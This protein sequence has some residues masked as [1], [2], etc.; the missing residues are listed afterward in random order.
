[1]CRLHADILST[2]SIVTIEHGLTNGTL[3]T[4]D[5]R[6]G[7]DRE[8][9]VEIG[10]GV[11]IVLRLGIGHGTLQEQG[12]ARHAVG[13]LVDAL[14]QGVDELE[15]LARLGVGEFLSVLVTGHIKLAQGGL[16]VVEPIHC[17][18]VSLVITHAIGIGEI[19]QLEHGQEGNLHVAVL[20][21]TTVVAVV[22]V[23]HTRLV[24]HD[25][26]VILAQV[27][28]RALTHRLQLRTAPALLHT[29]VLVH[30]RLEDTKLVEL[31][32]CRHAQLTIGSGTLRQTSPEIGELLD[33]GGIVADGG[34]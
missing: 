24:L 16:R 32:L 5:G 23:F 34:T 22:L 13:F 8:V 31:G 33:D 20:H 11:G 25:D 28:F 27:E 17:G 26:V 18:V 2:R 10:N 1:M 19:R 7:V 12:G 3:P 21:S 29:H 4:A 30:L 6:Q 14:S 9:I 15:Y